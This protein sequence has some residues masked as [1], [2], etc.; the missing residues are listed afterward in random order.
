MDFCGEKEGD[1][2]RQRTRRQN[3]GV[4]DSGKLEKK[5]GV[6]V[7]ILSKPNR[8]QAMQHDNT[9]TNMLIICI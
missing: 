9:N 2:H 8:M 3:G 5:E 6:S 7:Y 1:L 4:R